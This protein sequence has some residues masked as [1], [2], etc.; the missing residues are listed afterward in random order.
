[1]NIQQLE[2]LLAVNELRHFARAAEY[3]HVTQ[4]TLS[5]MLRKLEEE[6]AIRIFDRSR[7]LVVPTREG[8]EIIRRARII[9][10]EVNSLKGYAKELNGEIGGELRLG[11]IPTLAPYLL[12][13]FIREFAAEHP[14]LQIHVRDMTTDDCIRALRR[15]EMDLAIMS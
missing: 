14:L 13:L 12:P 4:P 3:C 6:L 2:Y 15:G 9:M 1:M 5:M 11:I 8:E 10:D 7:Q